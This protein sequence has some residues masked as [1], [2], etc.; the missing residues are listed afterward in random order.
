[1]QNQ[2]VPSVQSVPLPGPGLILLPP[3]PDHAL[4]PPD[5]LSFLVSSRFYSFGFN[6][7][8]IRSNLKEQEI[9]LGL[10]SFSNKRREKRIKVE[11]FENVI[12]LQ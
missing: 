7:H 12:M 1:M 2:Q 8:Q 4:S 3:V 9:R 5:V 6:L 11:C 10:L